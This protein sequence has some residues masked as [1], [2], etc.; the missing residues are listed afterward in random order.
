MPSTNTFAPHEYLQ[1]AATFIFTDHTIVPRK[2]TIVVWR[3][4][5]LFFLMSYDPLYLRPNREL[6]P[7]G[8]ILIL[9]SLINRKRNTIPTIR[10]RVIPAIRGRIHFP[11]VSLVYKSVGVNIQRTR[12]RK[13]HRTE[14]VNG[15][16][17]SSSLQS[18]SGEDAN[19]SIGTDSGEDVHDPIACPGC[20]DAGAGHVLIVVFID[21]EFAVR[22]ISRLLIIVIRIISI[23]LPEETGRK[24]VQLVAA[25]PIASQADRV[26]AFETRNPPCGSG[27]DLLVEDGV[28]VDVYLFGLG[29][30]CVRE[31]AGESG[32]V[33]LQVV[34]G[35][36]DVAFDVPGV[37]VGDCVV[38]FDLLEPVGPPGV[39]W[40]GLG[41]VRGA[42]DEGWVHLGVRSRTLLVDF[43]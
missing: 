22:V 4:F 40:G 26:V 36:C 13:L 39:V 32:V 3:N 42:G 34:D 37:L 9:T 29:H 43:S 11:V 30:A 12:S 27:G 7:P 2:S 5:I 21:L 8:C 15:D 28:F 23:R 38:A 14:V 20:A 25:Q 18:N 19:D 17:P 10:M 16:I 41:G 33:G 6:K 24:I 31:H 35:V 1:D